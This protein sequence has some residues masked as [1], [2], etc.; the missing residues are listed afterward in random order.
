[1]S[2]AEPEALLPRRANGT[3]ASAASG[4]WSANC[5]LMLVRLVPDEERKERMAGVQDKHCEA[6]RSGASWHV[7]SRQRCLADLEL[8]G[9]SLSTS[10]P[11]RMS[12]RQVGRHQYC[13][14]FQAILATQAREQKNSEFRFSLESW[15]PLGYPQLISVANM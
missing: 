13:T 8:T 14:S 4:M 9:Q 2:G 1:M 7:C 3:V 10:Q 6:L 11:R 5:R 12:Q 15:K